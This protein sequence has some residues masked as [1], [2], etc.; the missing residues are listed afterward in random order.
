MLTLFKIHKIELQLAVTKTILF[1]LTI[2]PSQDP[3]NLRKKSEWH[4]KEKLTLLHAGTN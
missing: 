4:E 2:Y 1:S 3:S